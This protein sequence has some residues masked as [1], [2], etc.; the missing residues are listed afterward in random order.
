MRVSVMQMINKC[1]MGEGLEVPFIKATTKNESYPIV[2][3]YFVTMCP[4]YNFIIYMVLI[5]YVICLN[6][7]SG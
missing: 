5:Y 4:L 3:T 7:L 1:F 2:L 6:G